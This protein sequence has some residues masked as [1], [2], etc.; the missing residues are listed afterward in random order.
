M[1]ISELTPVAEQTKP[2]EVEKK[3]LTEI[4]NEANTE[5]TYNHLEWKDLRWF[6]VGKVPRSIVVVRRGS[7]PVITVCTISKTNNPDAWDSWQPVLAEW[8]AERERTNG[9]RVNHEKLPAGRM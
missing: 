6:V 1:A 4:A 8:L 7:K 2:A 9:K 5:A 3:L